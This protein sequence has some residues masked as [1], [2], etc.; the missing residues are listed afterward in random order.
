MYLQPYQNFLRQKTII[1]NNVW[2]SCIDFFF[3]Y[4]IQENKKYY[5]HGLKCID[6]Y[7]DSWQY[8]DV[9]S[10][11]DI[12]IPV[13]NICIQSTPKQTMLKDHYV[14]TLWSTIF[15]TSEVDKV[16]IYYIY[17]LSFYIFRV[18]ANTIKSQKMS[19]VLKCLRGIQNIKK[20]KIY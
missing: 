4:S 3:T 8:I 11:T 6:M 1:T 5:N 19:N 20:H 7:I 15:S 12:T 9:W 2:F 13:D 16:N 10:H 18:R 14:C 17:N